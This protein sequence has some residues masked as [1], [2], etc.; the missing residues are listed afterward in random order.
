[1]FFFFSF[2]LFNAIVRNALD[3]FS[4]SL[5][6]LSIHSFL[7]SFALDVRVVTNPCAC[8]CVC[9]CV[10]VEGN[11]R[12]YRIQYTMICQM[13]LSFFSFCCTHRV[14]HISLSYSRYICTPTEWC[15][16]TAHTAQFSRSCP[17]LASRM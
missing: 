7:F 13:L 9:V 10:G 16:H 6:L 15:D 17:R 12:L 2:D 5:R 11:L 14:H 3:N 1:M 8:V 4:E